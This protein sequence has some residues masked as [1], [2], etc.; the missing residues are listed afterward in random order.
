MWT[1]GKD[2]YNFDRCIYD[3]NGNWISTCKNET[4][5]RQIVEEHNENEF[6]RN[7]SILKSS[8]EERLE[9]VHKHSE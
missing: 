7:D 1:I 5:T 8:E 2:N 9:M 3:E 4:I 6:L